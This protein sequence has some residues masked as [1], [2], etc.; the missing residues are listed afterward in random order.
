MR[1]FQILLLSALACVADVEDKGAIEKRFT[2][3]PGPRVVIV[4]NIMGGIV[5]TGHPGSDVEVKVNQR[6]RAEDATRLARAK[7]DITVQMTLEGATLKI[8]TDGPFR[9]NNRGWNWDDEGYDF[10]F[11]YELRVPQDA[12]VELKTVNKGR[13]E[14]SNIGDFRVRHVNGP[15]KLDSVRGSGS[16]HTVNGGVD[17]VF[18]QT[19]KSPVSFK[20]VNGGIS[21]T[22]PPGAGVDV[23]IKSL[24]GEAYTDFET[25]TLPIAASAEREGTRY[26]VRTGGTRL[27]IGAGGPEQSF[28]M[29]N[30]SVRI[31]KGKQ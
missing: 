1:V 27:R 8:A 2:L 5:V 6:W 11:D 23:R 24:H 21:V 4:D 26:R 31:L 3:P 10:T 18:T 13:I 7:R 19:P 15:V 12:A 28:E 20:T 22:Y 25:T 16:V 14:A 17:V 29:V 30:G 9:N